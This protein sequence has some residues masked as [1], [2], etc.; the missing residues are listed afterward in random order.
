[1]TWWKQG[2]KGCV[3]ALVPALLLVTEARAE[4]LIWGFQAEQFE[5]RVGEDE[6]LLAWDFDALA[7]TDE[8]KFVWRSEA[9]YLTDDGDFEAL[10]NQFRL[11]VPVS[12]FFDAVAGVRLDTPSGEDRV[13]GVIGL[14]GL[15]KQWVEVDADVFIG[16]TSFV[17]FEAEYEGL[18]TNRITL[19]PSLELDVPLTDDDE[20]GVGAFG[21]KLEAGLRLSYDVVD[22]LFSPY[23]GVHYEKSFGESGVLARAEGEDTG[24]VSLVIGSRILF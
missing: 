13:Y 14:H 22:R 21:P 6:N 4:S 1:M 5:Y 15:A 16:E 2:A 24:A 9:E 18:I 11:Q 19:V 10:E 23:V 12:D 8:L 3:G 17:R 20:L 7:G